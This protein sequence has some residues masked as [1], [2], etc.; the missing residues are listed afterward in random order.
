MRTATDPQALTSAIRQAVWSIDKD[1]PISRVRTMEELADEELASRSQSMLL[2]GLF[3]G[4]ALI[5]ASIGIYGVLSFLVSQRS[6]EI[7]VRMAMGARP[8]QV[9]RL[10]AGR[11]IGLT[12][13]GLAIGA[14]ASLAVSRLLHSLLYGVSERDPWTLGAV[15]LVLTLVAL[16]ACV[17]PARRAARIDPASALRND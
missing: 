2:L 4:L 8:A 10:V 9:L 12:T 5:L 1:Q 16:A 13:A 15:C 7:A 3:A 17:I 11:G 14:A 6:R